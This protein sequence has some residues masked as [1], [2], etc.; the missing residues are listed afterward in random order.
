MCVSFYYTYYVVLGMGWEL[1]SASHSAF[2]VLEDS[3]LESV[4]P[5]HSVVASTFT[6]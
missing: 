1:D 4:L 2:W 3:L 6:H 5:F